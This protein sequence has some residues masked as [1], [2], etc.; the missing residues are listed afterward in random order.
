MRLQFF[1][2]HKFHSRAV[3]RFEID[4]GSD[5]ALECLFPTR[6]ADAPAIAWLQPGKSR[7]RVRR[8]KVIAHQDRV[9]EKITRHFRTD[10]VQADVLWP[11]AAIAVTVESSRRILA[12]QAQFSP[13]NIRGHKGTVAAAL[14]LSTKISL[15]RHF[16]ADCRMLRGKETAIVLWLL[17]EERASRYFRELIA[18]LAGEFDAPDF[19]P[20]VTLGLALSET[21]DELVSEPFEL[22]IIG[23]GYSA[24]FTKTLFVRFQL[25]TP[26]AKLRASLGLDP[27]GY[28]PHLSLLYREMPRSKKRRIAVSLQ[29]PFSRV[30][31]DAVRAVRCS[32]PVAT[33]A[34]VAGWKIV[35]RRSL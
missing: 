13:K 21:P 32:L 10:R 26:L 35:A 22:A 17:P 14:R 25:S 31:F 30:R 12:A 34:D 23:L 27:S 4:R 24:E 7:L 29:L 18:S 19:A 16:H 2:G 5:A 20:H 33:S 11:G 15:P 9:I 6:H 3:G 1:Q 8:D 28:D